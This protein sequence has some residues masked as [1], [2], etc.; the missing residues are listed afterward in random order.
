VKRATSI[1]LG[2]QPSYRFAG[3][4]AGVVPGSDLVCQGRDV[5]QSPIKAWFGKS[6][7]CYLRHLEPTALDWGI[8]QLTLLGNLERLLR[9]KRRVQGSFGASPSPMS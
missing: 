7:A 4:M 8:V 1:G 6:G 5:A 9:G 3:P 2:K